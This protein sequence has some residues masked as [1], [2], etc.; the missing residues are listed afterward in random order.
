MADYYDPDSRIWYDTAMVP[1]LSFPTATGPEQCNYI[2]YD[3]PESIRLKGDYVHETRLGGAIPWTINQGVHDSGNPL[4]IA[5][6]EAILGANRK[7]KR[8]YGL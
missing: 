4:L 6:G 8:I 3:D 5:A 7:V 2:S 1:Y